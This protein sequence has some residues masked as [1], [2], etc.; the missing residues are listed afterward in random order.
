M[1]EF[2]VHLALSRAELLKYYHGH[3]QTI[4][5][6]CVDGRRIRFPAHHVR[7][8]VTKQGIYGRFLLQVNNSKLTRI[9]RLN[10]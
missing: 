4:V 7:R 10:R 5:A 6:T 9:T 3:A 8:F 1:E 2:Q